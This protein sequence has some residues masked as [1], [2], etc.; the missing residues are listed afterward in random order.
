MSARNLLP[1]VAA[2]AEQVAPAVP[3]MTREGLLARI[4][5]AY[6]RARRFV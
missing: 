3:P 2:L 5:L 4:V 1:T 6:G